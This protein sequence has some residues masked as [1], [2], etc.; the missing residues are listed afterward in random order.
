MA[1]QPIQLDSGSASFEL[2][3]GGPV[4]GPWP[5]ITS[6][7]SALLVH[8]DP[9][10]YTVEWDQPQS[11]YRLLPLLSVESSAVSECFIIDSL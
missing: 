8:V 7:I 5:I 1:L 10:K 2:V 6:R 3:M 11:M 9:G 4:I